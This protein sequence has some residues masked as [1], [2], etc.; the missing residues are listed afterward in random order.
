[1]SKNLKRKQQQFLKKQ[2]NQ[3]KRDKELIKTLDFPLHHS[4]KES[5][6]L[7]QYL[8]L[9][10]GEKK[11]QT[12]YDSRQDEFT[13]SCIFRNLYSQQKVVIFYCLSSGDVFGSYHTSLP[14]YSQI[15]LNLHPL[16]QW[17]DPKMVLFSCLYNGKIINP[18]VI[19][20]VK[21]KRLAFISFCKKDSQKNFI[22]NCTLRLNSKLN[23]EFSF[24]SD[25]VNT[26]FYTQGSFLT[27]PQFVL[28][29]LI[30]SEIT[31][32]FY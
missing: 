10:L 21:N 12:I 23:K 8:Y 16:I 5:F 2:R 1:M 11:F 9:I 28:S 22:I 19:W 30:I 31:S 7:E 13:T 29:R 18:P 15:M 4:I 24:L 25:Q 17:E 14:S 32:S 27:S 20:K 3:I 26:S 6:D